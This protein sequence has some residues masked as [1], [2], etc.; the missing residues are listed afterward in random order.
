MPGWRTDWMYARIFREVGNLWEEVRTGDPR[1]GTPPEQLRRSLAVIMLTR[2]AIS[3]REYDPAVS[4][5]AVPVFG[6]GGEVV[7]AL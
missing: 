3:R 4:A 5:A 7:A 6:A 2:V 1:M